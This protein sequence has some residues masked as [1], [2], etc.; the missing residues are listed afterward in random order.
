[1]KEEFEPPSPASA[2]TSSSTSGSSSIVLGSGTWKRAIPANLSPYLR[3]DEQPTL[4][5]TAQPT[6]VATFTPTGNIKVELQLKNDDLHVRM[7]FMNDGGHT[8][9]AIL[10]RDYGQEGFH[11]HYQ[12]LS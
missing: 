6:A 1:M 9:E 3:E 5:S 12:Q 11:E 2:V 4:R 7:K 10:S 8:F